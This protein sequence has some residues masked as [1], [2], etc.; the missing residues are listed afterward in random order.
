ML[1]VAL[2]QNGGNS[3]TVIPVLYL[4]LRTPTLTHAGYAAQTL[5]NDLYWIDVLFFS[6]FSFLQTSR[7]DYPIWY[8]RCEVMREHTFR[9]LIFVFKDRL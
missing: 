9:R 5:S 7:K 6:K 1:G 4:A 3:R 8:S 2:S